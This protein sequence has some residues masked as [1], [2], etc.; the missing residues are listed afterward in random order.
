VIPADLRPIPVSDELTGPYWDAAKSG[1]LAI[2]R[3]QDCQ[4]YSH[5]PRPECASCGS[6]SLRFER[7]S[8]RGALYTYTTVH[9]TRITR[10]EQCLPY[11]VA[12]VELVEQAGI[13]V[14]CNLTGTDPDD[15][16]IDM[17]VEVTFIELKDGMVLPDFRPSL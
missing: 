11:V 2:Q 13:R 5:P 3:C 15:V 4:R 6:K 7:V 1:F 9:D 10:F 17:P 16:E 14:T 8:G 12:Q